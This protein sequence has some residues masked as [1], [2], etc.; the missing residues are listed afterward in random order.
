MAVCD[1]EALSGTLVSQGNIPAMK[2]I[3]AMRGLTLAEI[4]DSMVELDICG[5]GSG[6]REGQR[7]A[8]A[9]LTPG[10]GSKPHTQDRP[11]LR[12]EEA[13]LTRQGTLLTVGAPPGRNA[14]ELKSLLGNSNARLKSGASLVPPPGRQATDVECVTLEQAKPKAQVE[15]DIVLESNICVQ[16]SYLKGH[17]KIVVHKPQREE[18]AVLLAGGKVRVVGFECIQNE[19]DRH[20][21][22]QHSAPLSAITD[23]LHSLYGSLPDSDGCAEAR[24]GVHVLPFA[25]LLPLEGESGSAVGVLQAHSGVTVRYI[26]LVS[27]A[28]IKSYFFSPYV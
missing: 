20:T 12:V 17:V 6:F 26:A 7:I 5:G 10:G 9:S 28:S 23:S 8:L 18:S 2:S 13:S 14:A 22:Y 21:F 27:V 16:G 1:L 15:V 4:G 24:E 11:V 19:N 3:S 25:M